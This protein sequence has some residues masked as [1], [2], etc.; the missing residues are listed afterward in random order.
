MERLERQLGLESRIAE[1]R[2]K[3]FSLIRK[4]GQLEQEAKEMESGDEE[5][6]ETKSGQIKEAK[7]CLDHVRNELQALLQNLE[8]EEKAAAP[9]HHLQA[10]NN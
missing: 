3:E 9:A 6:K 10:L 1:M 7:E 5:E 8:I 2:I 4:F